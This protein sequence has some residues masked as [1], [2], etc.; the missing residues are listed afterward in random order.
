MSNGSPYYYEDIKIGD[1]CV[2]LSRTITEADI[3]N[4]AG[5]SGDYNPLHTDA[6]SAKKSIAG[7]RIAHGLLI[8]A[9]ASGLFTRTEFNLKISETLK[10]IT[11]IERWQ[12]KKFVRI[13]D[14]IRVEIEVIEKKDSKPDKGTVTLK[15]VIMNQN[16]EIV[17]IGNTI[18]LLAKKS[19]K[20][21]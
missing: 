19:R 6:V 21:E 8:M 12:F 2:S 13:G 17:Q 18:L 14:T 7:E 4:F 16:N 5:I 9:I 15:R 11:E 20:L 10:A 3:V 1:K